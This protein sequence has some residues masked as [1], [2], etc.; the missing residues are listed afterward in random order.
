M[1]R[2]QVLDLRGSHRLA[3]QQRHGI[4]R[5]RRVEM[6]DGRHRLFDRLDRPGLEPDLRLRQPGGNRRAVVAEQP[7]GAVG[8]S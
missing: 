4:E 1:G 8:R 2:G 6:S 5:C 7:V 3:E